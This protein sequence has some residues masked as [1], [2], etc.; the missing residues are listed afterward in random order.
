MAGL[1]RSVIE[2][3]AVKASELHADMDA[4]AARRHAMQQ[5][6]AM[7]AAVR[8]VVRNESVGGVEGV[9]GVGQG[10]KA[11]FGVSGLFEL[12]ARARQVL[13]ACGRIFD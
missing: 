3:A 4:H 13:Q 12:Q 10:Q 6:G 5:L 9:E 1:P 2:R 11:G 8:G 7:V